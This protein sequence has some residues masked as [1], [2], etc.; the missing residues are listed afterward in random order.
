MKYEF[1][2]SATAANNAVRFVSNQ[3]GVLDYSIR[4]IR[5]F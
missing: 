2:Y 3:V 4:F 5:A 1:F